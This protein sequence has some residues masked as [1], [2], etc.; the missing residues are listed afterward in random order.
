MKTAHSNGGN[1]GPA[2]RVRKAIAT[3]NWAGSI[4]ALIA[5]FSLLG[6]SRGSAARA[7][8]FAIALFMVGVA[9]FARLWEARLDYREGKTKEAKIQAASIL[10][11][12]VISLVFY[13]H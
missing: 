3:L 7:V 1:T 8:C 5:A 12:V 4:L 2:D 11:L 10:A 6:L 13:F 9:I